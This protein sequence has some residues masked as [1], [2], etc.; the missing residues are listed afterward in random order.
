MPTYTS[1]HVD[2]LL[3][4]ERARAELDALRRQALADAE[5]VDAVRARAWMRH[6]RSRV[7]LGDG[8]AILLPDGW[9]DGVDADEYVWRQVQ[10]ETRRAALLEELAALDD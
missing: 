1:E 7:R 4:A 3:A 5:L 10:N 6:D 8:D 2:V 9:P